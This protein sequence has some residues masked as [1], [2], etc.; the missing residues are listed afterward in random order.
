MKKKVSLPI[1]ITIVLIVAALVFTLAYTIAIRSMNK[2]L[3][4]LNEK[5]QMFSNYA[6]VDD[7]LRE[8]CFQKADQEE[9]EMKTIEALVGS[10]KGTYLLTAQE[11]KESEFAKPE[12]K[13]FVLANGS[14]IVALT[15]EQ[16]NTLGSKVTEDEKVTTQPSSETLVSE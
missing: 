15:E 6:A 4:D 9:K 10:Y 1:V 13:T 14:V 2:K 3:T 5:Q 8:N 16:Y 7:F 12:Y 11:Y